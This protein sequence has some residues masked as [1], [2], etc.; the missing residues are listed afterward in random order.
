MEPQ[1]TF[2]ETSA[3]A[4]NKTNKPRSDGKQRLGAEQLFENG[5]SNRRSL[6]K[7]N[8]LHTS[9]MRLKH[10]NEEIEECSFLETEKLQRKRGIPSMSQQ[11]AGGGTGKNTVN[12]QMEILISMLKGL[13][14]LKDGKTAPFDVP[15]NNEELVYGWVKVLG[16]LTQNK[17]RN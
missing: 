16:F 11:S 12:N 4:G 1:C 10:T 9:W 3:I 7:T 13:T 17:F 2:V 5:N 14:L 15:T 6:N 8:K